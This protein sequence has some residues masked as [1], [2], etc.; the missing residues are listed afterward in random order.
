MILFEVDAVGIT[1]GEFE[2]DAPRSIDVNA[3][4]RGAE[5]PER[6]EIKSRNI[7]VGWPLCCIQRVEAFKDRTDYL[8]LLTGAPA[9]GDLVRLVTARAKVVGMAPAVPAAS[10]AGRSMSPASMAR[11]GGSRATGC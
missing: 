1:L 7:H 4:A 11:P 5:A 10:P 6:V 9:A 3:V 8:I 2:G